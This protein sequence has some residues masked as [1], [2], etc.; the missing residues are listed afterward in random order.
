MTHHLKTL[1]EFFQAVIDGRKPMEFRN[2]DRKFKVGDYCILEEFEGSVEV[3]ACPD[4]YY[5]PQIV[6][7]N[8]EEEYFDIPE[9][10][11]RRQCE[12]Y[13]KE[14]YTG[15]RCLVRIKELF[16]LASAGFIDYVAFTF[17]IINTTD[18][19]AVAND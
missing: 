2:N 11:T 19:K 9:D 7:V 12:A 17:D 15:R 8:D 6:R 5:C 16:D 18:K 13:T 1:P 4:H 14:I 10:C 3:P